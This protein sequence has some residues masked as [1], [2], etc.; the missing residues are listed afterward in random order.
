MRLLVFFYWLIILYQIFIKGE[1]NQ[2]KF[3]CGL[4]IMQKLN[5]REYNKEKLLAI[6]SN[7]F[8]LFSWL[9]LLG[10]WMMMKYLYRFVKEDHWIIKWTIENIK[11]PNEQN[12]NTITLH[13]R[14]KSIWIII[15]QMLL[16][17]SRETCT[18]I[19]F[20]LYQ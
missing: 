20:L 9:V 3:A 6:H 16:V 11:K 8:F 14:T 4:F 15:R 17:F 7:N 18:S 12:W 10:I 19:D 5:L 2:N 1:H 13:C